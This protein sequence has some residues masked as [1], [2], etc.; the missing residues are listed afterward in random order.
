V[1]VLNGDAGIVFETI[2]QFR[3]KDAVCNLLA[4]R[5]FC[6]AVEL[7]AAVERTIEKML[8]AGMIVKV[9]EVDPGP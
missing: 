9:T 6:D 1:F 4:S 8:A 2:K 7:G 5:V 3:S